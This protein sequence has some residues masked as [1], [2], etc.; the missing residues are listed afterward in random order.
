MMAFLMVPT[1]YDSQN[2]GSISNSF[3]STSYN[4]D[5]S[6]FTISMIATFNPSSYWTVWWAD[7]SFDANL[8][9][10][11]FM[12]SNKTLNFAGGGVNSLS[13]R[14]EVD[15]LLFWQTY[16]MLEVYG[17]LL[18]TVRIFIYIETA[19]YFLAQLFIQLR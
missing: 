9:Y 15:I 3:I 16:I 14:V 4:I 6:S 7:E 1:V 8:G 5:S 13:G 17:I 12:S 19:F 10:Y 18:V 2:G 11:A